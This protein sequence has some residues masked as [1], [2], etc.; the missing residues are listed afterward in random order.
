MRE[1]T[2]VYNDGQ[3]VDPGTPKTLEVLDPSTEEACAKISLGAQDKRSAIRSLSW[4]T[5]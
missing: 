1:Y 3:C 4:K 5:A 2:P